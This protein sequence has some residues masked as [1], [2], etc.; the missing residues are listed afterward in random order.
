VSLL[1]KP[2]CRRACRLLLEF[3]GVMVWSSVTSTD[4][5]PRPLAPCIGD[6]ENITGECI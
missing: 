1:K 6:E 5:A 4:G 3:V 2:G